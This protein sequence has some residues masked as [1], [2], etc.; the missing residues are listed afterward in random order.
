MSQV[1]M[2]VYMCV[3]VCVCV[4]ALSHDWILD[5]WTLAHQAPLFMEFSRQK[6]WSGC[7][8]LLQGIFSTQRS[9][10]HLLC[11]LHW[12]V[13]SLP[14]CHQR[15]PTG[16]LPGLVYSTQIN[17]HQLWRT[18]SRDEG[19]LDGMV[20]TEHHSVFTFLP[21]KPHTDQNCSISFLLSSHCLL[22]APPCFVSFWAQ[23]HAHP[24]LLPGKTPV[25]CDPASILPSSPCFL[26][27]VV[28]LEIWKILH[29]VMEL[30]FKEVILKNANCSHCC[31]STIL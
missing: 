1:W 21:L 25:G 31:K 7:H 14:L 10:L 13:D 11:L 17:S 2:C 20:C 30:Q 26:L 28:I 18:K 9:N 12:Q 22:P 6:Y 29:L 19:V 8:F 5:P 23:Y 3:S 16:L 27:Q 4:C 15:S 24:L